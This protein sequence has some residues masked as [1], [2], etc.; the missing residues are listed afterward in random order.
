MDVALAFAGLVLALPL[1]AVVACAIK[2]TSKGPVLFTQQRVGERGRIFVLKK[3]R[4]MSVDA[5]VNGP[6]RAAAHDPASPGS[7]ACS[8][9]RVSMSYRSSGTSWPET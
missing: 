6:V 5:E 7:V 8:G 9:A 3:F 4:S 1:M 2:L